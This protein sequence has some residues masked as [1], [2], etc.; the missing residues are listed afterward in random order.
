MK[1]LLD[2]DTGRILDANEAAAD[3]YGWTIAELCE[4][5]VQEINT[6]T[7]AEVREEM[8]RAASGNRFFFRFSHRLASGDVRRVEVYTGP[9]VVEGASR[10]LSIIHDVTERENALV[11][12]QRLEARQ[13][14]L[15]EQLPFGV[16]LHRDRRFF[17]VNDEWAR[18]VGLTP[19]ALIGT[20][21]LDVVPPESHET[22]ARRI[23]AISVEGAGATPL[24][25]QDLLRAD[26][27][28][29]ATHLRAMP[30]Q[31]DGEPC[32]L[33]LAIDVSEREQLEE[34]LRRAQRMDSVGRLA[35][36]V[37]HDFNNLLSVILG[38]TDVLERRVTD[39]D[40]V[41]ENV[42][43]IRAAAERAAELTRQLLVLGRGFEARRERVLVSASIRQ[44][45]GLLKTTL[46]DE[47][48]VRTELAPDLHVLLPATSLDQ[49]VLNLVV[50]A[51]DAM[52]CAGTLFVSVRALHVDPLSSSA[53]LGLASGP[54][55]SIEVRDTGAGMTPE[56]LRSAFEP[57]FTTKE[58]GRGTGLGLATAY[59][60]VRRAG[61]TIQLESQI[62]R[63]TTA[64]VLLPRVEE[65]A[66]TDSTRVV[67]PT[68][69]ARRS[70]PKGRRILL[71][72]DHRQVREIV[73]Q[74]LVEAGHDV[75]SAAGPEEALAIANDATTTIEL[76]ITDVVMPKMHG[77]EL[78]KR[79]RATRP[80]LPVLFISGWA[81]DSLRSSGVDR[82]AV[83][84]KPFSSEAL[85]ARVADLASLL[86]RPKVAA[87]DP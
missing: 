63:G 41:S 65:D 10:L 48:E 2:P 37:A 55:V 57:F 66:A 16:A 58:P 38:S 73:Q 76:L 53:Q 80:N 69:S 26:G 21:P 84:E 81:G 45:L 14:T 4:M 52:T 9:V 79:I 30:F 75:L 62:G 1:L 61:G 31:A 36:G 32:V 60:I 7:D 35:G 85:L 74:L 44:L 42:V 20:D 24:M 72:D 47:I 51:K 33:V 43:R 3:F 83:L 86:P 8:S 34:Q 67:A 87:K 11:E 40:A 18:I 78:A 28:R 56:V 39:P 13:R 49:I 59:G 50:N 68:S 12:L 15:L 6:L 5:H 27:K 19:E 77:P 25:R 70:Q 46:G 82:D 23:A 54:Y 17:W 64:R 71:V 29:V 22:V